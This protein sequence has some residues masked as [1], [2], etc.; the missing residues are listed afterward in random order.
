MAIRRQNKNNSKSPINGVDPRF[1]YLNRDTSSVSDSPS[2]L[3]KPELPREKASN[4]RSRKDSQK[5]QQDSKTKSVKTENRSENPKIVSAPR[6]RKG[7]PRVYSSSK[8]RNLRARTMFS[9]LAVF[10]LIGLVN[11]CQSITSSE[12]PNRFA[13][14]NHTHNLNPVWHAHAR[15]EA[16]RFIQADWEVMSPFPGQATLLDTK[17]TAPPEAVRVSNLSWTRTGNLEDHLVLVETVDGRN[18]EVSLQIEGSGSI[19]S[20]GAGAFRHTRTPYVAPSQTEPNRSNCDPQKVRLA[21]DAERKLGDWADAWL[22]GNAADLVRISGTT[23]EGTTFPGLGTSSGTTFGLLEIVDITE[24]C[25]VSDEGDYLTVTMLA[26]DCFSGSVVAVAQNVDLQFRNT[27][28][29]LIPRWSPAG[30]TPQDRS[31]TSGFTPTGTS[32]SECEGLIA[33]LAETVE[34]PEVNSDRPVAL[35]DDIPLDQ[36][37]DTAAIPE[38]DSGQATATTIGI[39]TT[40]EE[41]N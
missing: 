21:P 14:P 1:E 27:S 32:Q 7:T 34:E 10:A 29:P 9:L 11:T 5:K 4:S 18:Y 13:E 24:T 15:D 36:T 22:S 8:T 20:S 30:E 16:T 37:L 41:S 35:L 17:V 33:V 39:S 40:E 2:A 6:T 38:I 12:D 26:V 19:N 23:T 3:E 28:N 25:L 31:Q